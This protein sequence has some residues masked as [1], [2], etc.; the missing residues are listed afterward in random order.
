MRAIFG[1][2]LVPSL[3]AQTSGLLSKAPPDVDE[4]LRGKV[5]TFY[6][7]QMQGKF[8]ASE[9]HVCE[10]SR[11][12][13]YAADKRQWTSAE[14][15]RIDYGEGFQSARVT[16]ALGTAFINRAGRMP[17]TVPMTATWRVESGAWCY[18]LPPPENT[19]MSTPFGV[20]SSKT[21]AIEVA[22]PPGKPIDPAILQNAVRMSRQEITISSKVEGVFQVALENQLQGD[23]RIE[24]SPPKIDGLSV[25]LAKAD[26]GPGEKTS[27]TVSFTPGPKSPPPASAVPIRAEPV[28]QKLTLKLIFVP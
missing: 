11:D 24:V 4:A 22:T 3:L 21:G 9:A 15:M 2:L 6:E 27:I 16:T 18:Y 20:M 8:R 25:S 12:R 19:G 26:L 17:V 7:L 10:D 28:G 5:R 1:I 14:I 23:V 13:Y